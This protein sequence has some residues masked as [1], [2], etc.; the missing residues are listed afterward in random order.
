MNKDVEQE[1]SDD[2][3]RSGTAGRFEQNGAGS[4][5]VLNVSSRGNI[6]ADPRTERSQLKSVCP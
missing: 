1:V 2:T 5:E 4:P 3:R 6:L